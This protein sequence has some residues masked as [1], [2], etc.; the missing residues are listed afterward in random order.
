MTATTTPM[1]GSKLP[2]SGNPA[3]ILIG[4]RSQMAFATTSIAF[5]ARRGDAAEGGQA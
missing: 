2:S 3:P 4:L 1:P 5:A